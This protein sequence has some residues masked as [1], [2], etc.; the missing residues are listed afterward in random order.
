MKQRILMGL[1]RHVLGWVSAYL[2]SKGLLDESLAN[3]LTGAV[4]GIITVA[5]SAYDKRG[6]SLATPP[7]LASTS[8]SPTASEPIL[9]T[10]A[11]EPIP[12]QPAHSGFMLSDES[13]ERL[14]GVDARLV[15]VVETALQLSVVDFKVTEGRRSKERQQELITEGKSWITRS[16]HQDGLAVDVAALPNNQL[17]WQW[18][19]YEQIN[20]AFQEAARQHKVRITWGG[21]W[22]Q[23]DG[24]HFQLDGD[25]VS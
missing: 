8:Q 18:C 16:K 10:Q 14:K 19:Y 25:L 6:A 5:W 22:K 20:E 12:P 17:S 4:L 13:R 7:A 3:E 1:M 2:V 9:V 15:R 24:V 23:R 11:L 21:H